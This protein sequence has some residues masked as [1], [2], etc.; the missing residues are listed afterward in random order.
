MW[1]NNV[2]NN[3]SNLFALTET[4]SEQYKTMGIDEDKIT[5]IPNGIDLN[6]FQDLSEKGEF[7]KKYDIKT[8]EKIIL[9]LGRIH[10]TKR[11]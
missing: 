10:K 6:E 4:E 7:R 1:G 8:D 2:L 3:A 11:Y 5:I 9:Y